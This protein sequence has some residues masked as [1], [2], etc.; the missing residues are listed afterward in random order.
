MKRSPKRRSTDLQRTVPRSSISAP[1][2]QELGGF[3]PAR[4]RAGTATSGTGPCCVRGIHPRLGGAQ[5]LHDYGF[6]RSLAS[7]DAGRKCRQV[8]GAH[9]AGRGEDLRHGSAFSTVRHLLARGPAL[10]TGGQGF[11]PVLQGG[12]RR[13]DSGGGAHGSWAPCLRL[14]QQAPPMPPTASTRFRSSS[15]IPCSACS[16]SGTWSGWPA[17][18]AAVDFWSALPPVAPP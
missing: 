15:T 9:R 12:H 10:R 11:A 13:A 2:A 18:C 6:C 5:H 17:T 14:L 3:V 16:G 1:A 8:R 7:A 4:R